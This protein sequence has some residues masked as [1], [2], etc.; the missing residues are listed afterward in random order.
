[1]VRQLLIGGSGRSGTTILCRAMGLHPEVTDVPEW[2]FTTDPDGVIDFYAQSVSGLQSPFHFDV[3]LKR[4]QHLLNKVARRSRAGAVLGSA[5]FRQAASTRVGRNLSPAYARTNALDFS[6]NFER[7]AEKLI[8]DLTSFAYRGYWVGMAPFKS[9][10]LSFSDRSHDEIRASCAEFLNSV[11]ADVCAAQG[12]SAHL[13]KNTWNTLCWDRTLEVLPDAKLVHIVRHPLDVV[14]S[15]SAQSWVPADPVQAAR[16]LRSLMDQW[17]TISARVPQ[18]SFLEVRLEDLTRD[19]EAEF[20]RIC[21]F[22]ELEWHD[23]L[24]QTPLSSSSFGRWRQDLPPRALPEISE[25]V[26]PIMRKYAYA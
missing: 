18:R 8:A 4:L 19:P 1:M 10:S 16:I 13:E 24:L 25:I 12:A 3:R 14:S 15:Y 21:D 6:P 22:W 26:A 17:D 23:S 9:A 20:R 7:F 5:R 11:G 2:R